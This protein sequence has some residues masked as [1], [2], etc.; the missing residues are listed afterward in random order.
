MEQLVAD[1]ISEMVGQKNVGVSVAEIAARWGVHRG[2]IT[3]LFCV[4]AHLGEPIR[5]GRTNKYRGANANALQ[6]NGR[7]KM[8]E[9][10][11]ADIDCT[12]FHAMQ[13]WLR[14]AMHYSE[15]DALNKTREFMRKYWF[16][17]S[18]C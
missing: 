9:D 13:E 17:R 5:D 10:Q 2:Q 6:I 18:D 12:L 16:S 7:D 4:L 3:N 1:Q 14:S 11:D 8:T 15:R